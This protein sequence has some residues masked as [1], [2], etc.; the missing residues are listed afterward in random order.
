MRIY[1]YGDKRVNKNN[2]GTTRG[3]KNI[4]KK[5]RSPRRT[6]MAEKRPPG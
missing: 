4:I 5:T 1:N 6:R 3:E 2:S